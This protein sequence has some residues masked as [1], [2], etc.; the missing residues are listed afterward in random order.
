M[1]SSA[2][3]ADAGAT[4][5]HTC[6]DLVPHTADVAPS[7]SPQAVHT[8]QLK[9]I[10]GKDIIELGTRAGDGIQCFA[11]VAKSATAVELRPHYC[12][13]MRERAKQLTRPFTVE[14]KDYKLVK[15]LDA[16]VFMH[17][18]GVTVLDVKVICSL[19]GK[20]S[21]RAGAHIMTL[22]DHQDKAQ[23]MLFQRLNQSFPAADARVQWSHVDV[24]ER[25]QCLRAWNSSEMFRY[26]HGTRMWVG[27]PFHMAG[28]VASQAEAD[29]MNLEL[30]TPKAAKQIAAERC[31]RATGRWSILYAPLQHAAAKLCT[32]T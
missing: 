3:A 9:Y 2:V 21:I 10:V 14:C 5:S 22:I 8:Q 29:R 31:K 20:K 4:A 28:C 19:A 17:W 7:R 26:A 16:D 23:H 6:E 11:Q 18:M 1:A 24:D 13:L 30:N 15:P 32:R 25:Q 12:E 27:C